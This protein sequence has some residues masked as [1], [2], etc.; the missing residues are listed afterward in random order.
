VARDGAEHR[1]HVGGRDPGGAD[2]PRGR[3]DGRAA[4]VRAGLPEGGARRDGAAV[5]AAQASVRRA[6]L[7]PR[8]AVRAARVRGR[9]RGAT[10]GPALAQ[11]GRLVPGDGPAQ[12][13][14]VARVRAAGEAG[15]A[16]DQGPADRDRAAPAAGAAGGAPVGPRAGGGRG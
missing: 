14:D 11:R 8:V 10:A 9:V 13:R 16:R 1:G 5:G 15:G 6:V 3:P 4:R 12:L 7:Q 2:L